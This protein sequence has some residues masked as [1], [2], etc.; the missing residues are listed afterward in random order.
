MIQK[1]QEGLNRLNQLLDMLLVFG[2]YVFSSWFWLNY[3]EGDR[4]NMAALGPKTIWL[5]VAYA[6]SILIALLVS[7]FYNTTRTRSLSWKLKTIFSTVTVAILFVSAMLFLFRLQDFSRGVLLLFYAVTLLVLFGKYIL[8]RLLF[9]RLRSFGYNI[10]HEIVVG[11]GSLALQ[12]AEDVAKE[13]GLGIR[14][15]GF[16]GKHAEHISPWMGDFDRLDQI[17]KATDIDEAVLALSP[18]E[19]AH[20]RDMIAACEKNGVVYHVIPFYNDIIPANPTIETIGR[21]KLINM[22]VNRLQNPLWAGVKRTFDLVISA[23]G[24]ILLSPLLIFLAVGVRL[25]SPG[26]I[27]F[28]QTRVGFNRREF[29]MLKFR[30]MRVNAEEN[31]AW[32]TESDPRRTRFGSFIRKTSLDE[33]PQLLNVLRGDMSL[34]GPRPELPHFV[35]QFRETIPYYMVKHQVPAGMTGWA[36]I[37]GYRGDTSIEKR[38]ELDLWYIDHWSPWLDLNILFRTFFGGM[39]NRESL[40][41]N[42]KQGRNHR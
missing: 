7:G 12:Y 16:V 31:T 9:R 40:G 29:Q 23:L 3:L 6:F 8:M 18:E 27:L 35:E 37:H 24:L 1:N 5:S 21:S 38:V 15:R 19:Y 34:V 41:D 26:P 39:V 17:L 42:D 22:R 30:S 10:K 36:Q 13:K 25:S 20:I 33:L 28:K 32:S 2:S 11:T 4:E 14:I